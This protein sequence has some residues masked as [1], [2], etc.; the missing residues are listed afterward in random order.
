MK[1]IIFTFAFLLIAGLSFS[2]TNRILFE[3]CTGAWC[4]YCPCGHQILEGLLASNPTMLVLEYHGG[5]TD[6]WV[7]FNGNNIIGLL[8][9]TAYPRAAIGRRE[10]NLNRAYWQGAINNQVNLIPPIT[11]TFTNSFN[12]VTRQLTVD[13]SATAL[14][15]IDTSTNISFTITESNLIGYQNCYSS[16]SPGS[17][18]QNYNHKFVVRSMVNGALGDTFSVGS[19]A[20]GIT[21]TKTFVT[22]V[23]NGWNAANCEIGIFVYMNTT[24][25]SLS[26]SSYVLQTAKSEFTTTG[27]G[28]GEILTGFSLSQNYPNPF[29]PVTNI[30]FTIPEDEY[31][32]LK[33]YDILGK[34]VA[35]LCDCFLKA[36]AYNAGF[37]GSK[38]NSGVYYYRI[39][40]GDYT[41]TKKML[42]VK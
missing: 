16:C 10:L 15:N 4:G 40:A 42:L 32:T 9:Y 34:E 20:S 31:V 21:K 5:G 22:T 39:K 35:K 17:P 29:N 38:L 19:W 12:P 11:L 27:I 2:Q 3:G 18:V 26:A 33:V 7:S 13:V 1:K 28:Y 14:R 23:D 6:P 36:G 8:G 25:G 37:D 30:K 24:P 41:D